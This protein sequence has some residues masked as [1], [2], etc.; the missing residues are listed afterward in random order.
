MKHSKNINKKKINKSNI[1]GRNINEKKQPA[2]KLRGKTD[3]TD[4]LPLNAVV[5][6]KNGDIFELEDYGAAAMS[7]NELVLM[8]RAQ[9]ID[10]PHGSE[11]MM[12]PSTKPLVFSFDKGK[13]EVLHE[14]PYQP[15]EE[16]FPVAVFNSPGYVNRYFCAYEH[17]ESDYILPLFSYGACGW[18]DGEFMSAAL[19]VDTEPRQDLR[20]MPHEGIVSGVEAMRL[21][22]SE[23]RLMRHLEKCALSYGCPAAKNFFLGRY[24]APIP[25]S[26]ICNANCLGCISLQIEN[27]LMACQDRISFVPEPLEI[28]QVALE[29]LPKVKNSVASFGQGC[30]GDPLTAFH[31]IEPALR[32]IRE[33]TDIGTINMNTNAGMSDKLSRLFD[34]G[35]DSVRVSMNSVRENCYTAYFRPRSYTYNDVL[36]SI[37]IAGNKGKFISI[38]YLNCP[39][40]TDSK[41]EFTALKSFLRHY[42]VNMIQW[43]NMNYDPLKYLDTMEQV[44]GKSLALGMDQIIIELKKEFPKL[45]HGYFN[46]PK[47]FFYC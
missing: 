11:L 22:Y 40:F 26:K 5:A 46:P 12:L 7:G 33:K 27:N 9:A 39:G 31:V 13:F 17:C 29:H 42:P 15:G 14:N 47:E 34:A 4:Y 24:E 16:I 38:N 3:T 28:A 30:E 10:M 35:L 19:C 25:T 23:N 36:K 20:L 45:I 2:K 41:Q 43:R 18:G 21:K 6:N 32:I 1:N 37:E 8:T 44:C